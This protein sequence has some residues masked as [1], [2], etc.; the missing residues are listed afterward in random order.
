MCEALYCCGKCN[1][2]FYQ[3]MAA[4]NLKQ[5]LIILLGLQTCLCPSSVFSVPFTATGT[6]SITLYIQATVL[7]ALP[8]DTV[9]NKDA[10]RQLYFKDPPDNY[11]SSSINDNGL[12]DVHQDKA[13]GATNLTNCA[14]LKHC[15]GRG[16]DHS[17]DCNDII[18]CSHTCAELALAANCS[19]GE[20]SSKQPESR[21]APST[22]PLTPQ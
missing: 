19:S 11:N 8:F 15:A 2:L 6:N 14:L 20:P 3:T 1:P 16:A 13:N 17:F 22:T 21:C 4:Q 9:E 18:N 5:T 12:P 7:K 10:W